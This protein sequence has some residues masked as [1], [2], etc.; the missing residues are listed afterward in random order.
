MIDSVN[1]NSKDSIWE[2]GLDALSKALGPE[3]MV[4]FLAEYRSRK[5]SFDDYTAERYKF[6]RHDITVEELAN[7]VR[8]WETKERQVGLQA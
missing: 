5:P 7:E 6:R 2:Q 3:G 4:R 1:N 8:E